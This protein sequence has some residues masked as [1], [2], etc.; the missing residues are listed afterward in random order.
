MQ[1]DRRESGGS[2]HIH[3]QI[4]HRSRGIRRKRRSGPGKY[5]TAGSHAGYGRQSRPLQGVRRD[6]RLPHLPGHPG[7][8]GNY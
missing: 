8:R 3:D 4:Q 1:G 5:R 7:H 6:Q 2:L